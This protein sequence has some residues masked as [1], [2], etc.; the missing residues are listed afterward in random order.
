M[1]VILDSKKL[2]FETGGN[3]GN[4]VEVAW[5]APPDD[6]VKINVDGSYP[7]GSDSSACGGLAKDSLGRFIKGFYSKIGSCNA[8]WA[9]LW[10]L[11]NGINLARE[12]SLERVIFEMDSKVIVDMVRAKTSHIPFLQPLLQE[13]LNL[14]HLPDWSTSVEHIFR[15]ANH[16]ADLLAKKGHSSSF[17]GV[18]MED[19]F[20]LLDLY[21]LNDARGVSSPRVV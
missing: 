16:C 6:W 14:L 10:T 13:V 12:L 5:S 17:D 9:E 2:N 4:T 15:E 1:K 8:A 19:S 20:A 3:L 21:L 7:A 18:I 11:R